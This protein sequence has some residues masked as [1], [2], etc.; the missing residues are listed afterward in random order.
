VVR[1]VLRRDGVR[2]PPGGATTFAQRVRALPLTATQ[3]AVVAPLLEVL[4]ALHRELAAVDALRDAGVLPRRPAPCLA[5]QVAARA[6]LA[7]VTRRD[8][9]GPVSGGRYRSR[10]F[11][12]ARVLAVA[13][14]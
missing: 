11:S 5:L 8:P 7:G 3:A 1:A 10:T 13:A 4:A 6:Y 14:L 9:F 12:G 2:V